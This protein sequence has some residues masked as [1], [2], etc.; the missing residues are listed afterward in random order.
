M[1]N[2]TN[3]LVLDGAALQQ[4]EIMTML[5]NVSGDTS[6]EVYSQEQLT[7]EEIE[8]I[9]NQH[10][11]IINKDEF[12]RYVFSRKNC[13]PHKINTLKVTALA[14]YNQVTAEAQEITLSFTN[15]VPREK[16]THKLAEFEW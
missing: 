8:K 3:D 13:T 5:V 15:L 11:I 14:Q 10:A 9:R 6:W 12:Y 4:N 1:E 7:L 16:M 2:K